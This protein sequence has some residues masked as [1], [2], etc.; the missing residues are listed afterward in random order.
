MQLMRSGRNRQISSALGLLTA[1][2]L[3]AVAAHAQER[4]VDQIAQTVTTTQDDYD[5][6]SDLATGRTRIDSSVL[7]YQE[8]GGRVK[9]TEPVTSFT[10]NGS[11]GETLNLKLTSD[12]LTGATPNGAAPWSQDQV[13]TTPAHAPGTTATV[14]GASGGSRIVT[15]P[16]TGTV[17]RQ[18][19]APANTLPVDSGFRDQRYAVDIGYSSPLGAASRYSLGGSYSD[20]RDYRSFS[21]NAGLSRD[22]NHR[23]T[24]VSAA[25]DY[26]YDQSAPIFGTP[27]PFTEMNADVKG[28][29]RSK[30]VIGLVAGV[31]QVMNRYWL[32]QLNYSV[33]RSTGYQTDP[34]KIISVVDGVSGA[35]IR[36][37]YEG[38]PDNRLRQSVFWGNKVALGP[39]FAD[40]SARAYHDDWGITSY[41]VSL[42]DRIPFGQRFYLEPGVRYYNQ[43]AAD[44]FHNYLIDGQ[45]LPSFASSDSRLG[46]F[47]AITAGL[48]LGFRITRYSEI[49]FQYEDYRQSG[50]T[51]P[52]GAPGGLA[53]QNLFGGVNA[54]SAIIGLSFAFR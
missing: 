37:L 33:G 45:P 52:A 48:K 7:F 51:H 46:K 8:A 26:E 44:F 29:D 25:L 24:T 2:L 4:P 35:P 22:F 53:D 42:S 3:S 1:N 50:T 12:T 16:G 31:T 13:F 49:Y 27:T 23:N 47:S 40:F 21:V 36:Y 39:T 32:T 19:T 5:P 17:A 41:T 9:A 15:I 10:L 11:D 14:T 28:G 54:T 6:G 30:S 43:G 34:Y 38:R 18:Y 20:E